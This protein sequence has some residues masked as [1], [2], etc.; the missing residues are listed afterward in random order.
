MN[1]K[2]PYLIYAVGRALGTKQVAVATFEDRTEATHYDNE[3]VIVNIYSDV[4]EIE[5]FD[6]HYNFVV[7]NIL[8]SEVRSKRDRLLL[9]SDWTQT[10]EQS[11]ETQLKWR[12]YRQALRD[13]TLQEGFPH[14]VVYPTKPV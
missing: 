5:N 9:Q 11:E 13:L 14:N 10:A 3:G 7:V 12:P 8:S 4:S 1:Y 2:N 6:E